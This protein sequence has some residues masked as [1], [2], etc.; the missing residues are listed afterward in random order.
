MRRG[1]YQP[2]VR[3]TVADLQYISTQENAM[4]ATQ[5]T[6]D[7]NPLEKAEEKGDREKLT[8]MLYYI[9]PEL[10]KND[11]EKDH[12]TWKRQVQN[13]IKRYEQKFLSP[14]KV[15]LHHGIIPEK[16]HEACPEVKFWHDKDLTVGHYVFANDP[17]QFT[18]KMFVSIHV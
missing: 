5:M 7:F 6:L 2:T 8:T 18:G 10:V 3:L 17:I 11:T 14:C 1:K 15:I 16:W 9:S 13:G 12:E 4:T